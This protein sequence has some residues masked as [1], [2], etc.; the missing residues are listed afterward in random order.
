LLFTG[1]KRLLSDAKHFQ[2]VPAAHTVR[3]CLAKILEPNSYSR[4][5]PDLQ[6]FDNVV[7]GAYVSAQ[8]PLSSA[9]RANYEIASCPP[10]QACKEDQQSL[11]ETDR[12][13]GSLIL[14]NSLYRRWRFTSALLALYSIGGFVWGCDLWS[15]LRWWT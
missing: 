11:A 8:L 1:I 10:Q 5:L 15:L 2:L 14:A 3:G 4:F 6:S 7:F 13:V 12:E 9:V